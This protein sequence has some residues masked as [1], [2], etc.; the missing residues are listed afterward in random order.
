MKTI[1]V[2]IKSTSPP[3]IYLTSG[4]MEFF[5]LSAEK[6][7]E[8][9]F[10]LC[11]KNENNN[12]LQDI[13]DYSSR[14]NK[15]LT[16]SQM[17]YGLTSAVFNDNKK[18]L[19]SIFDY[20]QKVKMK[21]SHCILE[22][23]FNFA[24]KRKNI[25]LMNYLNE[26]SIGVFNDGKS[27]AEKSLSEPMVEIFD[28]N[29]NYTLHGLSTDAQPMVMTYAQNIW[30]FACEKKSVEA[31][32]FLIKKQFPNKEHL[33]KSFVETIKDENMEI[34]VYLLNNEQIRQELKSSRIVKKILR[35]RND[36][37]IQDI[38]DIW[39]KI[40]LHEK[41]EGMVIENTSKKI[42]I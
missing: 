33:E 11:R 9:F 2:P 26:K 42:K 14:F 3:Y 39:K 20:I 31:L 36:E 23:A 22:P 17:M 41:L 37:F 18:A 19:E 16:N 1:Q 5:T 6:K 13:L 29:M 40:Q 24:I 38:K 15:F 30:L 27:L 21:I 32:N 4:V 7:E 34:A 35:K 28:Q 25:E 12:Q 10:Y 8:Y